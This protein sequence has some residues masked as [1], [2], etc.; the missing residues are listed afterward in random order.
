MNTITATYT[1]NRTDPVVH[2]AEGAARLLEI[3][4]SGLESIVAA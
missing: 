1:K 4:R 3:Y 2:N